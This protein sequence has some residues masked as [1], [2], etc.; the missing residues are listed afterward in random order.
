MTRNYDTKKEILLNNLLIIFLSNAFVS[1]MYSLSNIWYFLKKLNRSKLE[2]K[3]NDEDTIPNKTQ[4]E[5]NELYENTDMYISFKYSYLTKTFLMTVF[6]LPLFPAGAFISIIGISL[7]YIVDKF[8]LL[9]TNKR[10]QM[11]NAKICLFYVRN[12]KFA[13]FI[14]ALGN[15][16]FLENAFY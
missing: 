11:L 9:N 10:P 4:R 13:I 14:Y 8:N 15:F 3:F 6:Y 2:K 12:F 1:P 5:L 7:V 16:I